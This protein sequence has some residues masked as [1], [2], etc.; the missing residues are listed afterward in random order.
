MTARGGV[1]IVCDVQ[2]KEEILAALRA[3]GAAARSIIREAVLAGAEVIRQAAEDN[4]PRKTGELA[5]H[6]VKSIDEKASQGNTCA[7]DV[8]PD[9]NHYYGRVVETG[10]QAHEITPDMKKALKLGDDEFAMTIHHPGFPAKPFLRPAFDAK[11]EE[12][13]RVIEEKLKLALGV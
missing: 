2:G 9:R 5:G 11:H 12:A 6:I 1:R 13:Q 3:R 8:G 4:A 7:V 10:A